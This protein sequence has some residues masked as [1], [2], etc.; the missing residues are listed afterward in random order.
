MDKDMCSLTNATEDGHLFTSKC[1]WRWTPVHK[2][3]LL[4]M[5]TCS[6]ANATEDGHLFTSKCHWRWTPVHEQMLLTMDKD[7]DMFANEHYWRWTK[8]LTCWL[9]L[10]ERSCCLFSHICS[11]SCHPSS[12][13]CMRCTKI[14]NTLFSMNVLPPLLQHKHGLPQEQHKIDNSF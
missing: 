1:Y 11:N 13:A 4:K 9:R 14:D 7:T 8:T 2:Q 5:D 3:M 6:L 10:C 12:N